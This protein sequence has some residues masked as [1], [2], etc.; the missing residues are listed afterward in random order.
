VNSSNSVELRALRANARLT[1]RE[2]A[3]LAGVQLRTYQRWEAGETTPHPS[4]L[5]VLN[6][7]VARL[8]SWHHYHG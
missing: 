2:M 6:Q 7:A 3:D 1:Q 5:V 4:M 8:L